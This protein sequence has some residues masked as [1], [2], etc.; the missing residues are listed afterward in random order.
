MDTVIAPLVGPEV[1][2]GSTR[3]KAGTAQKLVLNSIS[4][5]VM[6]LLGKTYGNLMVEVQPLNAKLRRRTLQIVTAVTGLGEE[7]ARAA[8]AAA[9][10]DLKTALVMTLAGVGADEARKR[11]GAAEGHVRAALGR[12]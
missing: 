12:A 2:A 3:M 5:T 7:Q 9:D 6:V 1:V 8:L 10:N 4:T 11:L